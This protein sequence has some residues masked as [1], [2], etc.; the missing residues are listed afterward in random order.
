MKWQPSLHSSTT[1][2]F[3][4]LYARSKTTDPIPTRC[5]LTGAHALGQIPI[6]LA[7][8]DADYYTSN[9]TYKEEVTLRFGCC[10]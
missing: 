4:F 3:L 7:D 2:S 9:G 5:D 8:I 10:F 1:V 6:D